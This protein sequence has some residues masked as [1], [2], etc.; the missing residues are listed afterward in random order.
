LRKDAV[1]VEQ[2]KT[3]LLEEVSWRQKLKAIMVKRGG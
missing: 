2:E 1:T 3:I